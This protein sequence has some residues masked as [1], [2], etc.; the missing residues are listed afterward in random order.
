MYL[1]KNN[2]YCNSNNNNS[3]INRMRLRRAS[4]RPSKAINMFSKHNSNTNKLLVFNSSNSNMKKR[5][6]ANNIKMKRPIAI[7]N[8]N[9][10]VEVI[11]RTIIITSHITKAL[12]KSNKMKRNGAKTNSRNL[13]AIMMN[14][15]TKSMNK[16]IQKMNTSNRMRTLQMKMSLTRR[17]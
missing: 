5:K 17:S 15:L 6:V 10:T 16:K 8:N 9:T 7:I 1:K 4:N 11:I 13:E 12:K 14:I 3:K 2:L